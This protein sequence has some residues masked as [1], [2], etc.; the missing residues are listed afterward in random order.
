MKPT[1]MG[2]IPSGFIFQQKWRIKHRKEKKAARRGRVK[3][4]Q[5]AE[6][7]GKQTDL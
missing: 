3:S 1:E 2:G 4:G 6:F 7:V 5:A